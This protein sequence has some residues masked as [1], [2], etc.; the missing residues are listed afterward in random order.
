M[1]HPLFHKGFTVM[2]KFSEHLKNIFFIIL[3]LQF[4]PIDLKNIKKHWLD[5]LEPKNHVG[6]ISMNQPIFSSQHYSKQ[7]QKYFKDPSI[8]AILLKI[9]CG[10]GAAGTT[11]AL[12]LEITQLK[13]EYPKPIVAYC[14]NICAS[15]AYYIAAS[16]DH[17]VATGSSL[18][19]SI[20]SKLSPQ[21]KVKQLLQDY[22]V[23]PFTISTGI[24]KDALDPL[25]DLT[26][27][28]LNMLQQLSDDTYQQFVK[29]IAKQRHLPIQ[30]K[31]SWA[32]GKIFT[33]NDA[34][35]QKLIDAVGNQ[36]TATDY[37]KQ[38]ILHS[39]KE[40]IFIKEPAL[41]PF[42]QWFTQHDSDDE[43]Q[44]NLTESFWS[45]LISALKKCS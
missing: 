43:M 9:D 24:Y 1:C 11:Q 35:K 36:S 23:Q 5:N 33:G 29:D 18:I 22:K 3:I 12:A 45:G 34:L 37:I 44:F 27:E 20:G 8:R 14:E 19:G 13:K 26:P 42:Q 17:I 39:D 31:D 7:L 10:G 16:T 4:A 32:N 30:Q 40:I 15:G 6:L 38:N 28:Q 25:T 41:S 2:A 21:F